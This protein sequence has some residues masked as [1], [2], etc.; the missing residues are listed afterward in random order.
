VMIAQTTS[1][2][3]GARSSLSAR[4]ATLP[5]FAACVGVSACAGA[6]CKCPALV[7]PPATEAKA[8]VQRAAPF[9]PKPIMVWDGEG[10]GARAKGWAS[11][12]KTQD[13]A[14][15]VEAKPGVGHNQSTGLEFKA[16]GLEWMG[17][18][19]NWFAWWPSSA[20]TDVSKHK[21]LS[22]WI[23][24]QGEPGKKP[25]PETVR[26]SLAGSSRGGKDETES[27]LVNDYA[28]GFADGEWHQVVVPI[29]PMLRGKGEAFDTYK[30]WSISIG[31]W[32]MGERDYTLHVDEIQ[33][34]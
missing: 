16:K 3:T 1:R 29:E 14:A 19:W 13:C 10:T 7:A 26:V 11:C 8:A 30:A 27:V 18:G 20:G 21:S 5:F 24:V 25:E 33:F 28:P 2:T 15:S 12:G 17:F 9:V 22:F 4:A 32:N 34:I 6:P 31:A 23:Q